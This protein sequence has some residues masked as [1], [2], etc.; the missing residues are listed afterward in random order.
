M[1]AGQ[2]TKLTK[3]FPGEEVVA[4]AA[5]VS[6]TKFSFIAE[7]SWAIGSIYRLGRKL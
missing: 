6:S 5:G 3:D 2:A 1:S 4:A 7:T